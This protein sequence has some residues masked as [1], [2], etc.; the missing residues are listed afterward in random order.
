M[1]LTGIFEGLLLINYIDL[2]ISII[3]LV[4]AAS[5]LHKFV[6][7]SVITSV[8]VVM[9]I[10]KIV[11]MLF[12]LTYVSDILNIALFSM[13]AA[14]CVIYAQEIQ[15]QL[16]ARVKLTK[17]HDITSTQQENLINELYTAINLL[18]AEKTGAIITPLSLHPAL[19]KKATQIF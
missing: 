13:A 1:L 16:N 17:L 10:L 8:V 18:S 2:A 5:L 19:S 9:F 7:N 11:A 14:F 15:R 6:K 12:G 3:L 4:L